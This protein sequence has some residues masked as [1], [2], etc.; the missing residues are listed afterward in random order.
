MRFFSG[1]SMD[2]WEAIMFTPRDICI[3]RSLGVSVGNPMKS[4]SQSGFSCSYKLYIDRSPGIIAISPAYMIWRIWVRL[5]VK[6]LSTTI[7][8][9]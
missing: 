9:S 3:H 5:D 6:S 1:F 4:I 8:R 7:P 2:F